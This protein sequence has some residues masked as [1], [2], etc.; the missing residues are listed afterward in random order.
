MKRYLIL[1]AIAFVSVL[2]LSAECRRDSVKL[3]YKLHGQ[4]R[5]FT[6]VFTHAGDGG[7][8]MDWAIERNLKMWRGSYTMTAPAVAS[9]RSMSYL[10]PEDG[11]HV[12]LPDGETF[13]I[14]SLEALEALKADGTADWAGT[15]YRLK[16]VKDGRVYA[17][18][19]IEGAE[20]CVLDDPAFPLVMSMAGNPLEINWTAEI[21]Q[22]GA[23]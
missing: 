9:A 14:L 2:S 21:L 3:T 4:T 12:T 6:A 7:I 18:D 13:A 15:V 1:I 20:I 10:M 11:R 5:R 17:S 23:F 19:T 22:N 8:R 16:E